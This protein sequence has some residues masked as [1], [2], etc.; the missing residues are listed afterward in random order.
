MR[1]LIWA[2][3]SPPRSSAFRMRL[4]RRAGS[5]R[6]RSTPSR[7]SAVGTTNAG[8][9]IARG[10]LFH[11]GER[12]PGADRRRR[13]RHDQDPERPFPDGIFEKHARIVRK[14]IPIRDAVREVL[15]CQETDQSWKQA[16]VRL[17]IAW[18]SFVRDFGPINT[19]VVSS[20]EDE[21][22]GEVRETHRRPNLAPFARRS[23][24]LAG[25]LDRGLRPREQYRE[26]R[27]D[28]HRAGDCAAGRRPSSLRR[29]TPSPWCSTSA[30][31]VDPDH[32]AELLHRDVDDVIAEL[33][34]RDLPRSEP[35]ARGRRRTP[36]SRAL[37]AI[38]LA[39]A[40][41]AA[42]L[43]PAFARNVAALRARCSP[44]IC[45]PPTSPPVS[46]RPGFP[47]P[48][49]PPSSR[50]RWMPRSRSTTRR[51]SPPGR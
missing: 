20:V 25:R 49:S 5:S 8:R 2:R 41:A 27:A 47:P 16:Q 45:V 23:R 30:A 15:K 21:E 3:R 42:E 7:R 40:D 17:R 14:L 32:V 44:P 34:E 29:P 50:R 37:S 11:R 26:A 18:S 22:T 38:K 1:E 31:H 6:P 28:L 43:D 13:G 48:T 9:R 24:L 4:R 39:A 19:T 33:G 12:R 36:T 35:T 51:S 10:Q 46:A